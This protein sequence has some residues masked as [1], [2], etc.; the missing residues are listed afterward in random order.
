MAKCP[1]CGEVVADGQET[2][3]A[4]GQKVR[5]RVRRHER[6]H[7][8]AVFV[9]AGVLILAALV[10]IIA[11]VSGRAK[12]SGSEA[13]RQEQ[14][15]ISDSVRAAVQAQRDSARAAAR[16]DATALMADEIN[17]LEQRFQNVRSEV[18]KGQPS[19]AQAKLVSEIS[20]EVARLRQLAVS[21]GDQPGSGGDSLREQLRDGQR[22]VRTLISDL[23]RAPKK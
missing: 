3:F 18:V 16:N 11:V 12:R 10:G 20:A 17:K 5:A 1:H 23:T 2:C 6:P 22:A 9:I 7:N 13:R 4:C 14:E 21:I 19:P 15:R 8:T